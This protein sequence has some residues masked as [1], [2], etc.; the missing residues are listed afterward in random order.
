MAAEAGTVANTS[1]AASLWAILSPLLVITATVAVVVGAIYALGEAYK[2]LFGPTDEETAA[3]EAQNQTI[4]KLNAKTQE[5]IKLLEQQA[6]VEAEKLSKT[7]TFYNENLKA[8]EEWV[9]KCKEYYGEDSDE[10]KKAIEKKKEA[11]K[12]FRDQQIESLAYI[13]KKITEYRRTE[14]KNKLEKPTQ[15][16]LG[17]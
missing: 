13:Q 8:V 4:E 3:M 9:E 6:N 10:Y 5:R 15:K 7:L 12:E 14:L 2:A 17:L 16:E 11:E 1:L